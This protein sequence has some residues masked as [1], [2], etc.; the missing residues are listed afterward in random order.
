MVDCYRALQS[1]WSTVKSARLLVPSFMQ[2]TLKPTEDL[3]P[4][5]PLLDV[6]P[7][8]LVLFSV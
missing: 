3:Q 5:P 8:T 7:T 4:Q 2:S 1:D 6:L